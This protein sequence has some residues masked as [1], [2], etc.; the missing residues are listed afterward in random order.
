M[1]REW[2]VR[3]DLRAQTRATSVVNDVPTFCIGSK[4]ECVVLEVEYGE[5]AEG[6][7]VQ[8][9]VGPQANDLKRLL[10][11]VVAPKDE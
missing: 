5:D 8:S 9:K 3:A 10:T 11:Y 4:I 2:Q 7:V 6:A 1:E